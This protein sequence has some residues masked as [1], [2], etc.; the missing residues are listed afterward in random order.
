LSVGDIQT[1]GDV[2]NSTFDVVFAYGILYHLSSPIQA[3]VNMKKL[4]MPRGTLALESIV[5]DHTRVDPRDRPILPIALLQDEASYASNQGI[6]N[7]AFWPS[8]AFI[9]RALKG[10]GFQHV[11]Q[12]VSH[13]DHP[14]FW[15]PSTKPFSYREVVHREIFVASDDVLDNPKLTVC[16]S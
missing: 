4:L 5:L 13:P 1:T 6:F 14:E 15:I 16:L 3:L 7:L 2:W 9:I 10:V 8:V 11:Y 12:P